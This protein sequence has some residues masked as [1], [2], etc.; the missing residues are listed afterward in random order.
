MAD[1]SVAPERERCAESG[2]MPRTDSNIGQ[3][4]H[5]LRQRALLRSFTELRGRHYRA[6]RYDVKVFSRAKPSD[7]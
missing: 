6:F 5:R 7:S 1:V 4:R 2:L 3:S